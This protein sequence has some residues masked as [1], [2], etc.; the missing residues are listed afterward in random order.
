MKQKYTL[1]EAIKDKLGPNARRKLESQ[2]RYNELVKARK[3]K[4][5]EGEL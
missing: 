2:M 3:K 5:L 1:Y 4:E